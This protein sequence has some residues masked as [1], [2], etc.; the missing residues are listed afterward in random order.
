MFIVLWLSAPPDSLLAVKVS[1]SPKIEKVMQPRRGSTVFIAGF[2]GCLTVLIIGMIC[3]AQYAAML[4]STV[5]STGSCA[6]GCGV[7]AS[8]A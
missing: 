8:L 1:C 7:F 4:V 3:A 6:E 2:K 5:K